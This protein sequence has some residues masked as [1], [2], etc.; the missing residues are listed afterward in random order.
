MVALLLDIRIAIT[1]LII[2]N[3]VMDAAQILRGT[4]PTAL[5]R[6]FAS[7][8]IC[9]VAG[10]FLGTNIL[11]AVPLYILDQT[12]GIVVLAT[13]AYSLIRFDFQISSGMERILSPLIGLAG[14]VLNGMTNTL[15]PVPALYFYGL[16]MEKHEFVKSIAVNFMVAKVSQLIAVSTWNLLT[17]STLSLSLVVT[18]FSLIGFSAG[19]K[20][21]DRVN[22]QAFNRAL[23][24]LLFVIGVVLVVKSLR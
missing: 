17:L 10:V 1:L 3:I 22:Q 19:L 21:Q 7:L 15:S 4:F 18:L 20:T 13:V 2:P 14:G 9:T 11:V 6:R 12:L 5:F 23:L 8:F 24:T 16:K